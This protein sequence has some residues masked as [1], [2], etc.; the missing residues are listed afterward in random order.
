[1][2]SSCSKDDD[3]K[4]SLEKTKLSLLENNEVITAPAAMLA[5][6]DP[7]AQMAVGYIETVNGFS[8]FINFSELPAGATKNGTRIT[9]SNGR[10]SSGGRTA[11]AGDFVSYTWSDESSGMSIAYQISET[12]DSYVFE[13]FLIMPDQTEWLKYFEAEE[14][15]DRSQGH[16][17]IYDIFDFYGQGPSGTLL[18]YAWNRSGDIFTLDV[19]DP[20]E[21]NIHLVV[22]VK[23]KAGSVEYQS[24]GTL[25]YEMEW[26]A[27]GNGSW[28]Y[29]DT[30]GILVE[31]GQWTV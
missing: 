28:A 25:M 29:Y 13:F 3:A 18:N 11:A 27:Q 21:S 16:M 9:A 31:E 30:E 20:S 22:N 23:T 1:V 14:K 15:K 6:S 17:K 7:Y 12:S 24:E 2:A 10:T 5:S 19:S 8:E 4:P 26:D